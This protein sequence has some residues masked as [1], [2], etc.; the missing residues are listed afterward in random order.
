MILWTLLLVIAMPGNASS[1]GYSFS[2]YESSEYSPESMMTL[3]SDDIFGFFDDD[4]YR[5]HRRMEDEGPFIIRSCEDVPEWFGSRRTD[6]VAYFED[7]FDCTCSGD[8]DSSFEMSCEFKED[9]CFQPY[10]PISEQQQQEQQQEAETYCVSRTYT[11]GFEVQN[12][13]DDSIYNPDY[14]PMYELVCH[15][16]SEGPGT[17]NTLCFQGANSCAYQLRDTHDFTT[18]AAVGVCSTLAVCRAT[19]PTLGYTT[20]EIDKM[21]YRRF[22]NGEECFSAPLK[23]R[24]ECGGFVDYETRSEIEVYIPDCSDVQP[25]AKGHCHIQPYEYTNPDPTL[26]Y[27]PQC[28]ATPPPTIPPSPPP[29]DLPTELPTPIPTTSPTVPPTNAPTMGPTISSCVDSPLM[30]IAQGTPRCCQWISEKPEV[31]CNDMWALGAQAQLNIKSH[32]PRACGGC[33]DYGCSDTIGS[34]ILEEE[35]HHETTKECCWLESLSEE[36]KN[37]FCSESRIQRTC[38]ETCGY[39]VVED[40]MWDGEETE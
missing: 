14:M 36:M 32:C 28:N 7:Y 20:A 2:S 11:I 18:E 5:H 34:F 6:V 9:R 15:T 33:K 16:F 24:F 23:E 12:D 1:V 13:D 25:C 29:T 31:R 19:L 17:G 35:I 3:F 37:T 30:F 21:C 10:V 40:G 22:W 38:K 26:H 4:D 8:F 27:Y 39:C